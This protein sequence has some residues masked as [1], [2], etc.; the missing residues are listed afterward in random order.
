MSSVRTRL[1]TGSR[2]YVTARVP[3]PSAVAS[4]VSR[5]VPSYP[6]ATARPPASA[7]AVM[8][9]VPSSVYWKSERVPPGPVLV[10]R[11]V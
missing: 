5:Y 1:P 4:L 9:P 8:W 2:V 10:T 11:D 7:T 6:Y 3:P